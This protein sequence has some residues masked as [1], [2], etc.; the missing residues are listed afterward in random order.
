MFSLAAP[1]MGRSAMFPLQAS[2][3]NYRRHMSLE[4]RFVKLGNLMRAYQIDLEIYEGNAG[5][6]RTDGTYPDFA[7][8]GICAW[9]Y[10]CLHVFK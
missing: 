5:E 6:F 10:G 3:V 7:K 9:M 1:W 2:T 4:G 8:E